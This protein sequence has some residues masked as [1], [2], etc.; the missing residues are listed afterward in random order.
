MSIG[1]PQSRILTPHR[2]RRYGLAQ[3][4]DVTE[5]S[6]SE[7]MRWIGGSNSVEFGMNLHN[8][9]LTA[10]D[11]AVTGWDNEEGTSASRLAFSSIM[12]SE[13]AQGSG[14]DVL[15]ALQTTVQAEHR[16]LLPYILETELLLGQT[17]GIEEQSLADLATRENPSGSLSGPGIIGYAEDTSV[18]QLYESIILVPVG[19]FASLEGAIHK[20]DDGVWR[21]AAGNA[22]APHAAGEDVYVVPAPISLD[23][24][25]KGGPESPSFVRN[26]NVR[27]VTST[28]IG[29]FEVHH[30]VVV[31]DPQT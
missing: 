25:W 17:S 30:E 31:F 2:P 3:V 24:T 10:C 12:S 19:A 23:L 18:G 11:F 6:G 21:S 13:C 27:E 28:L 5:H 16:A 4:I 1:M 14:E 29:L 8:V 26:R 22:V 15:L 9:T 7:P 20:G